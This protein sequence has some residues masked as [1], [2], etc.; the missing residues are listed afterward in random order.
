LGKAARGFTTYE[1]NIGPFYG[2]SMEERNKQG[3]VRSALGGV[4]DSS[5]KTVPA[6]DPC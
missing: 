2:N 3:G 5:G 6:R 4:F 1:E